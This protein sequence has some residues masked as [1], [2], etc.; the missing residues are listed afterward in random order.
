MKLIKQQRAL[1]AD[2]Q[3]LTLLRQVS[4][5]RQFLK[6]ALVG[7][8]LIAAM[9]M[10]AGAFQSEK[11]AEEPDWSLLLPED[12]GKAEVTLACS[13]CHGLKQLLTLKKTKS[14]WQTSVQKM[15]TTYQAPVD[16]EDLPL[17][18]GYLAKHFGEGNP[19][20]QLPLNVNTA[21]AAALE[22]LPGITAEKAKA[23]IECRETNGSF[24]GIEDLL[25]V[26]SLDAGLLKTIRPFIKVRD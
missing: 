17:V 18:V 2:D 26:S 12:E 5:G 6:L 15:M 20:D 16:K 25:R 7:S 19:L 9:L 24:A 1:A 10:N 21:Q 3:S 8:L 23:I 13:N 11:K 22:R 4:P 14:G